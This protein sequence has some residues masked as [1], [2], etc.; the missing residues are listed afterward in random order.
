MTATVTAPPADTATAERPRPKHRTWCSMRHCKG[1]G[2]HVSEQ[3]LLDGAT[4]LVVELFQ[5]RGDAIP[6]LSIM[7]RDGRE[8]VTIPL[9]RL[10]L[11]AAVLTHV[12]ETVPTGDRLDPPGCGRVDLDNP[13]A[14][15]DCYV[16]H[17]S[18]S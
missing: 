13:P 6:S 16:T 5:G 7:E 10:R 18:A 12:A 3:F 14:Y 9:S 1:T 8:R 2:E 11:L 15:G 4:P 17:P